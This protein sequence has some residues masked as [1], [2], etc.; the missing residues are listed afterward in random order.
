MED[1]CRS[2]GHTYVRGELL[3]SIGKQ[4]LTNVLLLEG[5][6]VLNSAQRATAIEWLRSAEKAQPEIRGTFGLQGI[7]ERIEALMRDEKDDSRTPLKEA[8]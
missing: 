3:E 6:E 7:E 1:L 8:T 2:Y 5:M 4:F